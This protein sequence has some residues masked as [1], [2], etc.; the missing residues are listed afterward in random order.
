MNSRKASTRP[1]GSDLQGRN[2][3][4]RLLRHPARDT[5]TL[6]S[7]AFRKPTDQ[8]AFQTWWRMEGRLWNIPFDVTTLVA[9]IYICVCVH[10]K[11]LQYQ[12]EILEL[13]VVCKET[14]RCQY[15]PLPPGCLAVELRSSEVTRSHRWFQSR[16]T[17][18]RAVG[19]I[20]QFYVRK[21]EPSPF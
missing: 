3:Y 21:P 12:P 2:L 18:S 17:Y 1:G 19:P 5:R 10:T 11:P 16:T 14:E 7:F 8:T 4:L 13:Q 20:R 9:R 15:S 6:A